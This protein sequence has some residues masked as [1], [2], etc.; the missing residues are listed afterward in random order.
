LKE[1]S[2][3]YSPRVEREISLVRW[4]HYGAPVL[5]FP[6][7]GGDAEECERMGL[8]GA[9]WS[10]VEAGRVKL[11]SVD[12]VAGRAWIEKHDPGYCT[13]L[14]NRFDDFVAN[15]LVPAIRTDCKDPG[16][17]VIATGASIGAFNAV[18]SLCRHPDLFRLAIGMSGTYDLEP[19]LH[20]E[21]H[22][23]FHFLSPQHFLPGLDGEQ[24]D[25][26]RRR[27]VLMATGEGA[28]ED[29]GES[30]RMAEALGARDVPNRVDSWGPDYPHDWQTWREMLPKYLAEMA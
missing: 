20:G 27:F 30:W 1:H 11:Y 8:V 16:I 19:W 13:E 22:D 29:P 5:I 4:G 14:Q 6:T 26:L 21:W 9:L 12:S 23:G 18:A 7:A 17:E 3:W 25:L 15:E 2:R 10:L 28:W 24:L